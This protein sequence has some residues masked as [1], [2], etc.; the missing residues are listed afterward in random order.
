[1]AGYQGYNIQEPLLYMRA[2]SDMYKRRAGLKYV[3]TQIKLFKFMKDRK[4]ISK[5][6]YIESCIIRSG[7]A[8]SPNWMRKFMFETVLRK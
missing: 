5:R 8:L 7:S 3:K 1:M 6:Q 4:F 2:G